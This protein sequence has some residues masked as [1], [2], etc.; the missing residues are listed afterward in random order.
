MKMLPLVSIIT[1]TTTDRAVFNERMYR[2]VAAQDY[3]HVEHIVSF[4]QSKVLGAKMNDMI[5]QARGSIIV[6]IDSD[7]LYA[8]DWVSRMVKLITSTQADVCGLKRAYFW[9]EPEM[10]TYTYPQHDAY[11]FG[12]TMCHTRAFWE[13]N[14]YKTIQVGY[15]NEFTQKDC[16]VAVSDYTD[17]FVATVHA[18]NTSPKNM[19]GERWKM[20]DDK[21]SLLGMYK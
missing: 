7:D 18:S 6:N 10:W 17:G 12:A 4:D 14:P 3:S 2:I 5:A 21:V 13:R 11:L 19:T 1:P 20:V 9:R 8:P 15:D 16:K